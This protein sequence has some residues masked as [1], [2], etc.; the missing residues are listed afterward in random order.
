MAFTPAGMFYLSNEDLAPSMDMMGGGIRGMLGVQNEE[1]AI[2]SLAKNYDITDLNQREDFF[3]A[4]RQINPRTEVTL[5]KEAQEWD[6][7]QKDL[8]PTP[9]NIPDWKS[10]LNAWNNMS[11]KEREQAIDSG[12]FKPPA[13]KQLSSFAEKVAFIKNNPNP[14]NDQLQ[15]LGIT[16]SLD[17]LAELKG[18]LNW[19]RDNPKATKKQL[20]LLGINE[21]DSALAEKINYLNKWTEGGKELT[22]TQLSLLG[23]APADAPVFKQ[24]IAELENELSSGKITQTVF[25]EKK[26]ELIMGGGKGTTV[27]IGGELS[28]G[29]KK[30]DE[31]YAPEFVDWTGGMSADTTG[32]IVKMKEVLKKLLAGEKLT[33]PIIGLIPDFAGAFINPDAIGAREAV[34]SVVQ[35]NLKAVL[36]AQFTEKEGERLIKR[37]YNPNLS[38]EENARRLA[39][40]IEQMES[41]AKS[42]DA[43]AKYFRK[44]GT[45]K[46][47][48]GR[49]P[50][51]ADFWAAL[52]GLVIGQKVG[53]LTYIGGP[54]DEESSYE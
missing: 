32:N 30:I 50:Q 24:R 53:N 12:V 40:L 49:L 15:L 35:R 8:M 31:S 16:P 26:L 54:P 9:V 45:L 46:G 42:K 25:D 11:V 38:G 29:W 21:K 41:A 17:P 28:P 5:R 47:Y 52:N 22:T 51:M 34:E 10:K 4:V 37:A 13:Q 43:Q 48:E 6:K 23:I 44:N 14:T 18:K 39:L 36:G 19:L 27:N 1:E 3:A 33:G 7:G 20:Q 2:M